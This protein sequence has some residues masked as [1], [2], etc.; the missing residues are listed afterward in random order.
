MPNTNF[1]KRLLLIVNKLN[2]TNNFKDLYCIYNS[3]YSCKYLLHV[4]PLANIVTLHVRA[5]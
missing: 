5:I 3:Y 1:E 4:L 2:H